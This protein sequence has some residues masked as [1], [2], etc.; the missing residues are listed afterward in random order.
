MI[1]SICLFISGC[2][3]LIKHLSMS[4][5]LFNR[6]NKSGKCIDITCLWVNDTVITW[7]IWIEKYFVYW[8]TNKTETWAP[9]KISVSVEKLVQ[10]LHPE[11]HNN[12][13][14]PN[15]NECSK[16]WWIFKC[17]LSAHML[18]K[19]NPCKSCIAAILRDNLSHWTIFD[20]R[21]ILYLKCKY[22]Q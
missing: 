2:P 3:S 4:S 9:K 15:V 7:I 16:L 21:D 17:E 1:N 10:N 11:H 18:S 22:A 8:A 13:N 6:G 20:L 14:A 19:D 5:I 12:H